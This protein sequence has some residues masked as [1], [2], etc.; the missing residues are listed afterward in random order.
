M[1]CYQDYDKT[2]KSNKIKQWFVQ[3]L[4][5]STTNS[6]SIVYKWFSDVYLWHI[7]G[8]KGNQCIWILG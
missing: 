4:R 8:I 1:G 2:S 7:Q 3:P 6:G 5:T